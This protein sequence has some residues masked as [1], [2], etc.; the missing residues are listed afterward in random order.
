MYG[1]NPSGYGLDSEINFAIINDRHLVPLEDPV[2]MIDQ[3][4]DRPLD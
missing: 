3:N 1:F 4:P 2:S